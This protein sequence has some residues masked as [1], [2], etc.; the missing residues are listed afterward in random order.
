MRRLQSGIQRVAPVARIID[1]ER[2]SPLQRTDRDAVDA[3]PL[4]DDML[5]AAEGGVDRCLVADR[6]DEAD[7]VRHLIPDGGRAVDR[8]RCSVGHRGQHLP[9]DLHRLGGVLGRGD[10]FGDDGDH[11]LADMMH[12]VERQH[13][14]GRD[15]IGR[16]VEPLPLYP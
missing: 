14:V 10:A 2:R 5:G 15:E 9:V 4:L 11:R 8:G 6:V 12:P 3:E 16:A 7:I 1:A 13:A